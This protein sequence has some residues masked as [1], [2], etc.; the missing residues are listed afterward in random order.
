MG[1]T[2]RSALFCFHF[3]FFNCPPSGIIPLISISFILS[4]ESWCKKPLHGWLQVCLSIVPRLSLRCKTA[5][6]M[7]H[8]QVVLAHIPESCLLCYS[9]GCH[10]PKQYLF[11]SPG[12]KVASTPSLSQS[13]QVHS[14]GC[15]ESSPV[16]RAEL[17]VGRG[18][19]AALVPTQCPHTPDNYRSVAR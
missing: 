12:S 17:H 4:L 5:A 8:R 1:T 3:F 18:V 10:F 16:G 11:P 15:Q 6:A 2:Q 13:S 9:P 7:E 19:C 14:W